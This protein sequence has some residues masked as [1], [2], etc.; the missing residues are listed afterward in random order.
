MMVYLYYLGSWGVG[1]FYVF[2]KK[3]GVFQYIYIHIVYN[4]V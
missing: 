4:Y 2:A 3:F 1:E